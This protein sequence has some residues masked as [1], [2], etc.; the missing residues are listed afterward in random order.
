MADALGLLCNEVLLDSESIVTC[1]ECSYPYHFGMCPGISEWLHR[2]KGEA[3]HRTL[4]CSI[5]RISK[6]RESQAKLKEEQDTDTTTVFQA[7]NE[8]LDTLM[9]LNRAVHSLGQCRIAS[10]T[11]LY[12]VT[13]IQ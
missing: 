2:S 5:C 6:S 7:I 12:Q 8:R 1:A 13:F 9:T 10:T 4:W 3:A 11:I